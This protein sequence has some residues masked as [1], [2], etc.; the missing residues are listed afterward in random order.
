MKKQLLLLLL[1][2]TFLAGCNSISNVEMVN[3][4][5]D[6]SI[7]QNHKIDYSVF[8]QSVDSVILE[9]GSIP[10]SRIRKSCIYDS[11]LFILD[12]MKS[13]FVYNT[14]NGHL[15]KRIQKIGHG[16]GEYIEP[17]SVTVDAESF[18]LLDMANMLI[19][20]YDH[21]LNYQER[22]QVPIH[23]FDFIK[24]SDGFFMWNAGGYNEL[25]TIVH[26]D[27]KGELIDSYITPEMELDQL[28]STCIFSD[29]GAGHIYALQT[30]SDTIYE[31][32]DNDINVFGTLD[33]GLSSKKKYKLSSK[34]RKALGIYS[35]GQSFVSQ[36]YVFSL[37]YN[38]FYYLINI[39]DRQSGQSYCGTVKTPDGSFFIPYVL[40]KEVLYTI[41]DRIV[42]EEP[43]SDYNTILL[44]YKLKK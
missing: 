42:G 33:F 15:I 28:E 11:L 5:I 44:K 43:L 26:I 29:D 39:Y 8:A 19:L 22:I 1:F 10:L 36:R 20:K 24:V 32:R 9:K 35:R 25:N 7:D 12:D 3:I 31:W 4:P 6:S 14:E 16:E 17:M 27:S 40:Y 34:K 23:S 21:S 2:L 41:S 18:Y 38:N 13:I 37:Y 30:V